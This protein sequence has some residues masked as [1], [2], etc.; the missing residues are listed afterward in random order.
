MHE[1]ISRWPKQ[2]GKPAVEISSTFFGKNIV[3]LTGPE[4]KLDNKDVAGQK[5]LQALESAGLDLSKFKTGASSVYDKKGGKGWLKIMREYPRN[6][7][8]ENRAEIDAIRRLC[9]KNKMNL[10]TT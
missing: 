5:T 4:E 8:K 9:L 7:S 6:L 2:L 10:T 3:T 1:L